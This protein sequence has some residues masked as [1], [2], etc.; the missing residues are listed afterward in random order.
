MT[1]SGTQ[2]RI[3]LKRDRDRDTQRDVCVEY[4]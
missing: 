3:R 1:E 2:I 4:L